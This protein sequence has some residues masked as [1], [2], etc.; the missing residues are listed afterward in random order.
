MRKGGK[1]STASRA[2]SGRRGEQRR[3]GFL[4]G[5]GWH[6][7]EDGTDKRAPYVSGG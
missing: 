6:G 4:A 2:W 5:V 7:G 3:G 1:D